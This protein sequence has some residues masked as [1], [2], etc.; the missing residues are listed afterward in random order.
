MYKL[1]SVTFEDEL[2]TEETQKLESNMNGKDI[3]S[4]IFKISR[5]YVWE[6]IE[7]FVKLKT[8]SELKY[9]FVITTYCFIEAK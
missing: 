4:Q 2:K 5:L 7:Y 1:V 8:K 6:L 3:L 9:V